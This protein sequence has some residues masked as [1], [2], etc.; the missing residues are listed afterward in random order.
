MIKTDEIID[1]CCSAFAFGTDILISHLGSDSIQNIKTDDSIHGI[2][3]EKRVHITYSRTEPVVELT[4]STGDMVCCSFNSQFLVENE[5]GYIWTKAID[6][7]TGMTLTLTSHPDN[8][9]INT[10]SRIVIADMTINYSAT[11][12]YGI[13]AKDKSPFAIRLDTRN[14]LITK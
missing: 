14:Y 9:Y 2:Y 4:L 10:L 11:R 5:R 8:R 7:M 12:L 1:N 13:S 6:L 3:G